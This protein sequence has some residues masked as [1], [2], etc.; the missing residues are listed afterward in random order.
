[1]PFSF[2][3]CIVI[4]ILILVSKSKARDVSGTN[5]T[6]VIDAAAEEKKCQERK[7]LREVVI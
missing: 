1:M 2:S 5:E 7:R 3:F 4:I 6:K